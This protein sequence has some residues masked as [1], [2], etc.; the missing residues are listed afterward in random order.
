MQSKSLT[1][2]TTAVTLATSFICVSRVDTFTQVKDIC[3]HENEP[4]LIVHAEFSGEKEANV[5]YK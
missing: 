5:A 4:G 1:A 3:T 2:V